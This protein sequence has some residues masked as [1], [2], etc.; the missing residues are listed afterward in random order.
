MVLSD[1][2]Y[3]GTCK[4]NCLVPCDEEGYSIKIEDMKHRTNIPYPGYIEIAIEP[5]SFYSETIT[6]RPAYTIESLFG[7]VGGL[8]GLYLGASLLTVCELIDFSII[9]L[10]KIAKKYMDDIGSGNRV[11]SFNLEETKG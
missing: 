9:A 6:Q 4:Q 7:D 3:N 5:E 10:V 1:D 2:T 8:L 11:V